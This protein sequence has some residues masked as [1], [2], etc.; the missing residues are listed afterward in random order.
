MS[1]GKD[2]SGSINHNVSAQDETAMFEEWWNAA[3]CMSGDA[4]FKPFA[5]VHLVKPQVKVAIESPDFN[6]LLQIKQVLAA[7]TN[8][9]ECDVIAAY[10]IYM[11]HKW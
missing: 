6:I 2:K 7:L 9:S 5:R 8:L 11:H 4:L 10:S 3:R 1:N